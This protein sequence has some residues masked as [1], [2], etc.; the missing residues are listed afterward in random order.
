MTQPSSKIYCFNPSSEEGNSSRD[1]TIYHYTSPETIISIL[2]EG[3]IRF[4]DCQFLNDRS[5]YNHI[6]DPLN[7]AITQIKTSLHDRSLK[8]MVL[9]HLETNYQEKHFT[10]KMNQDGQMDF[11]A[12]PSRYFVF[13]A[14]T[15]ADSLNMWN[16]YVK[17]GTY[18]GYNIGLSANK[19]VEQVPSAIVDNVMY[20][21]VVY[22]NKEKVSLLASL[23]MEADNKLFS[24][25]NNEKK[26]AGLE[27][28]T[29][30]IVTG[31]FKNL[32]YY[33]LFFK[34]KVFEGEK[35]YRIA[36][37][38]APSDGDFSAAGI[39]KGF[40]SRHGVITP[41]FD[42]K[43]PQDSVKRINLSPML[44]HELA[45]EGLNRLLTEKNYSSKI[46]IGKSAIPIR[47]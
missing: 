35:E 18:Q 41:H 3:T 21:G 15:D 13:C 20:G 1:R 43:I 36:I 45:S 32:Q 19:I 23:I 47:F 42:L 7:E 11:I 33:R 46:E 6:F 12:S 26:R 5:E 27:F 44:E 10:V 24:V 9:D 28:V 14:S 39:E 30:D 17:N 38:M 4:T 40:T 22:D 29:D 37:Q 34:N 31:L 2:S 8:K 25:L 16:Y